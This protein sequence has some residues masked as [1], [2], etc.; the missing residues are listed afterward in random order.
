MPALRI[1]PIFY[2]KLRN[3]LRTSRTLNTICAV[4]LF[5][6][7]P[8]FAGTSVQAWGTYYVNDWGYIPMYLPDGLTNI[9]GVAAGSDHVLALR[10]DGTVAAWGTCY[11][12]WGFQPA[13][14]PAGLSNVVALAAGEGQ[15]LA[16]RADGTVV[17][18][19]AYGLETVP[20]GATNV[21]AIAAGGYGYNEPCLA[22]RADGSVVAWGDNALVP[23]S[24]SNAVAVAAGGY[25]S[26]GLGADGNVT[27]WGNNDYGQTSVP[28]GLGDVV[29]VTAGKVFMSFALKADGTVVPWGQVYDGVYVYVP[30]YVPAGLANVVAVTAGNYHAMAMQANGNIV[31]WGLYYDGANYL[32][33]FA[34]YGLNNVVSIASGGNLAAAVSGTMAPFLNTPM[35]DKTAIVGTSPSFQVRITGTRPFVCQW[36]KNS[37][38]IPGET[39]QV[40]VITNVAISDSGSYSVAI[41]NRIGSILSPSAALNVVPLSIITQPQDQTGIIGGPVTFN[42]ICDSVLPVFY[43]W[44]FGGSDL[45]G[46]TGSSLTLTGL[47]AGQGGTYSVVISNSAGVIIS[48]NAVLTTVPLVIRTNPATQAIVLGDTAQLAVDCQAFLPLSYQ[49]Q[50]NGADL[51]GAGSNPLLIT[52]VSWTHKGTYAV[53]VS[54]SAGSVTSSNALLR[55]STMPTTIAAWGASNALLAVP[56]G[57]TNAAAIAAGQNHTLVLWADGTAAAWGQNNF[58]QATVPDAATNLL[59]IAAGVDHSLAL[60]A[61]GAVLAWGRND[62]GQATVPTALSNVI[63]LAAGANHNLALRLDGSVFAWGSNTNGQSNVPAGLSNVVAVAA[64]TNH[65]LALR[66]DGTVVA[67]G[68]NNYGQTDVPAGLSNVVAIAAGAGHSLALQDGGIVVAWGKVNG[69]RTW[70]PA[71]PPTWLSNVTAIA[72]GFCHTLALRSDGSVIA[73]GWNGNGQTNVPAGL[74]NAIGIAAGGARSLALVSGTGGPRGV[75]AAQPALEGSLFSLQV[76]TTSGR[77]YRLEYMNAIT[78]PGWTALPLVPGVGTPRTLSDLTAGAQSRFYRVREW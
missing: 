33:M 43:Q 16:L 44:R 71:T 60:R 41:S 4:A 14:V 35:L 38:P 22:V 51:P 24:L 69:G 42:V 11:F 31:V 54:N 19:N 66:E 30:T 48:S 59:A 10:Q 36:R 57:F 17:Q 28:A 63:A 50:F 21:V 26:L 32:P 56:A 8:T 3:W 62:S 9:V 2:P 58:G 7:L 20:A 64:G 67:W 65:S 45:P 70:V 77:V 74:M 29:D 61:D 1:V 39:N 52:N 27:A 49:W 25:H 37:V 75:I 68:G 18:W 13:I 46:Q 34:P 40:L 15:S 76:P 78:A 47:T 23:A 5:T 12:P 72:A 73:W 53:R 6:A 55:I